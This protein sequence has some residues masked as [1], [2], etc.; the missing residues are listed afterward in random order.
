MPGT[1]ARPIALLAGLLIAP[2]VP[3][4]VA[5]QAQPAAAYPMT[6][7]YNVKVPMRD[8]VRLSA[9][10]YRPADD[11][12]HPTIFELTPYNNNSPT[13]MASAWQHVRRGY[14]FITVDVR[15]RYDSDG[16]FAPFR[17]DGSDGADVMSWIAAQPWSDG[18]VATMGGS[19]LG[20]VQWEM[21]QERHP[22]HQAIVSYV[23]PADDFNDGTRYNGVPKLDLMFTWMMGMDGR[24]GQSREGWDW[25]QVMRGLPLSTLGAAVGREVSWWRLAMEHDRLDDYW[26]PLQLRGS[27][28]SFDIPS[29]NVTGW[30]EGQLKGQIQN[31]Q[32]TAA[33]SA[34]P[35]VHK[36]VVGPWLHSV[37]RNRVVGERDGGPMATIDLDRLR[38]AWLD[39]QL[40]GS[41]PVNQPNVVYF[42]PVKNEWRAADGWPI[43]GTQFVKFFLDSKGR[44]NT[45]LGDG[46]L[47]RDEPGAGPADRFTYDPANPVPSVSSRTA[48]A[49]GGLPQ[50]S[51]DNRAVETRDDVLVYTTAPLESGI[52]VTGPVQAQIYFAT[53]VL[54]TD[55]AVKLLDVAPD[56]RA[57]N[58]AEGIAR[59]KYRDSFA[60]PAALTPDRV[61][62]LTIELFP[63]S[64]FFEAGHRIRIE[65]AGSD[66]PNFGR[67]LNTMD[68]DTGSDYRVAHTRIEHSVDHPSHVLL[69][70]VPAG[71]TRAWHP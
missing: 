34:N 59:A 36:L 10:L 55:L 20:K 9:D 19:Y 70:I 52:E 63:T 51:V 5:A 33:T 39:A 41:R 57:L 13:S 44:A 8:Q 65:I 56:G 4:P 67:N 54:D 29:F 6:I 48:G 49:R 32:S 58:L 15:G 30:Y 7:R 60:E 38:D 1:G 24:V 12:K 18:R 64:N 45:L 22:A 11:R 46:I 47:R 17:H 50:G 27:Y 71:A 42:L 43:P 16:E 21:A 53:D 23:S 37:N 66:F 61:Y 62:A 26:A 28:R 40:L 2:T 35:D 68:S 31:Y 25:G 14:V 69:P 3:C